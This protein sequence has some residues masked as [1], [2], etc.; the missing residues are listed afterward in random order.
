MRRTATASPNSRRR[1][2]RR[3]TYAIA[4]PELGR[5]GNFKSSSPNYLDCAERA[6]TWRAN[7]LLFP[8]KIGPH[9]VVGRSRWP[10]AIRNEHNCE[11]SRRLQ[12]ITR[13][14]RPALNVGRMGIDLEE[15]RFARDLGLPEVMLA[16]RIVVGI[17]SSNDRTFASTSDF[18]SSGN[19]FTAAVI[20]TRPPANVLRSMSFSC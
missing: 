1:L 17:N 19:A 3:A 15:E 10:S 8:P 13:V 11:D 5:R 16:V 12:R 9:F 2:V 7:S 18:T 4:P 6:R 20:T 14:F